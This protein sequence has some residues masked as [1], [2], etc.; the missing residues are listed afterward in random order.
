[1]RKAGGTDYNGIDTD[2]DTTGAVVQYNYVH[3]NGDGILLC[4]F[5]FGDS[6]VRYNLL[7]NNSRHG[8]N[9]HSDKDSANQTYNNLIFYVG[10]ASANLIATSG[11]ASYLASPYAIRNNIF[12]TTRSAAMVA[13]GPGTVYANNL[14][15][16]VAALGS[17]PQTGDPMFVDASTHPNGGAAGPALSGLSGFQVRAGSPALEHGVSITDDGGVDF[18]G[19]PLYAG[20]PDIGPYERP[21]SP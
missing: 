19:D 15:S 18:W 12:H 9:L 3:D 4:Q 13:S 17:A 21:A 1:M 5:G 2:H 14:F 10:S 16:G 11:D 20:A 7:I 8:I 6:I